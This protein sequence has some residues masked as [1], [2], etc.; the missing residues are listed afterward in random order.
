MAKLDRLGWT[1]GAAI[2]SQGVRV[3][4]RANCEEALDRVIAQLP[5]G[6]KF[7]RSPIV[8]MM[9][10]ISA[11]DNEPSSRVQRFNLLYAGAARLARTLDFDVLLNTFEDDFNLAVAA[12]AP[13]RIFLKA[14]VVGWNGRAI[15]APGDTFSGKVNLVSALVEAGATYYSDGFAVLDHDGRVH[16]YAVGMRVNS[17]GQEGPRRVPVQT[18]GVRVGARRLPVGVILLSEYKPGAVFKPSRGTP[19]E[20]VLSFIGNCLSPLREP[21]AMLSLMAGVASGA[22]ILKGVRGEADEAVDA[23]LSRI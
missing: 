3:G 4:I 15:L 16:P 1:V 22:T 12:S 17:G 6:W 7:A 19:G 23:L 10:S 13:R 8:D 5:E 20:A 21:D 11:H 9:Y 2:R 18:M 14:G